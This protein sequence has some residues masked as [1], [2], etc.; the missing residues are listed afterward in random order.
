[1][2]EQLNE[3]IARIRTEVST[4]SALRPHLTVPME[5]LRVLLQS[6]E[7]LHSE[8]EELRRKAEQQAEVL[9]AVEVFIA[10]YRDKYKNYGSGGIRPSAVFRREVRMIWA[11][12]NGRHVATEMSF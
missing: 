10:A 9:E 1:M 2:N 5:E 11:A 8:K 7:M 6:L 4:D 3:I 12:M